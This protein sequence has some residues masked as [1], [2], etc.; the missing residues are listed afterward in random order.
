MA[1][2]PAARHRTDLAG[3]YDRIIVWQVE[4]PVE[5]LLRQGATNVVDVPMWDGAD[6]LSTADWR[7]L[8]GARVL[9]SAMSCTGSSAKPG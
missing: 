7:R 5:R 3:D 2:P 1:G 8:A 6:L 9:S 4:Q